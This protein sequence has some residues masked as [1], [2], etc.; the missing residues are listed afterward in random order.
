MSCHY[1]EEENYRKI[2]KAKGMLSPTFTELR[3]YCYKNAYECP[4]YQAYIK[5]M[6]KAQQEVTLSMQENLEQEDLI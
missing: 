6:T 2:C 1:L 4:T 5:R 3:L